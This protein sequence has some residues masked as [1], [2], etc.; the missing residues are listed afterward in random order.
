MVGWAL[1]IDFGTSNTAA[2]HTSALSGR[3]E[4][5]PLTHQSNLLP[6]W[7]YAESPQRILTG[8]A[9]AAAADRGPARFMPSPKRLVGQVPD[10]LLDGEE[11]ALETLIAPVL[12]AAYERALVAHNGVPPGLVVLTHPEAWSSQQ[13]ETLTTAATC[14]GIDPATI[15]TVSEPR[16]AAHHYSRATSAEPGTKI[17][18]FDFGGGT[19]DV[20][21]L[22]ATDA[23]RFEVVAARGDTTLGGKDFDA[24]LRR[25]IEEHLGESEPEVAD[26]L[27]TVP[28]HLRRSID[29]QIR[30]AKEHLSESPSATVTLDTGTG[31]HTLTVTRGEFD[32]LISPDLDRAVT[33]ARAT[34]T[35]AGVAGPDDLAALYLTGG[36]ARIPL[37]HTRLRELGPV[38]TLDDP[39]TVVAQGALLAVDDI[40]TVGDGL[41][42][43]PLPRRPVL[44]PLVGAAPAAGQRKRRWSVVAAA[45][46]GLVAVVGIAMVVVRGLSGDGV[47]SAG[48]TPSAQTPAGDD[49]AARDSADPRNV[50]DHLPEPLSSHVMNCKAAGFTYEGNLEVSCDLEEGSSLTTGRVK[51]SPLHDT[52]SLTISVVDRTTALQDVLLFRSR[53]DPAG[54]RENEAR[55]A[56]LNLSS[57]SDMASVANADLGLLVNIHG[58]AGV[59]AAEAFAWESGLF[60]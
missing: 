19:L 30:T 3:I 11:Y 34:L 38:A 58:V 29:D 35:D 41:D 23:G 43:V 50:T 33:L 4:T 1:S 45:T 49:T 10:A 46:V 24:R 32:E 37:V 52:L 2:A 9:A 14:A 36:S 6:S 5:L 21:V 18:V 55:T 27:A 53:Y 40:P 13:I 22:I 60:G 54:V 51:D 17:A 39:K 59:E 47:A 48:A 42:T 57:S 7:V 28:P 26:A 25:W 44:S 12:A 15:T 8:A 16:A 31:R 20:A 56:A